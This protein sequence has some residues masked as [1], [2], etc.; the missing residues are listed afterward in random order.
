MASSRSVA[1]GQWEKLVQA[2]ARLLK[3][4]AGDGD[5]TPTD[6]D[7][8]ATRLERSLEAL[9]LTTQFID[10]LSRTEMM[11]RSQLYGPGGNQ[12]EQDEGAAVSDLFVQWILAS[13]D[14]AGA[15]KKRLE[16]HL[17]DVAGRLQTTTSVQHDA[18][19]ALLVKL[20]D[21]V[22]PLDA[23]R[24]KHGRGRLLLGP[25]RW[26]VLWRAFLKADLDTMRHVDFAN[27][28][29]GQIRARLEG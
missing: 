7:E 25:A 20:N 13:G 5:A 8:I 2:E 29:Q 11:L 16:A 14:E 23:W 10:G 6:S 22:V 26:I 15:A 12:K 24:K 9:V 17:I 4:L 28:Y 21:S 18:S 19:R 1:P 3:A 27:Y